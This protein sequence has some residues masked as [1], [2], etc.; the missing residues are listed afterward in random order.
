L[1]SVY[2]DRRQPT[3]NP[4]PSLLP[5]SNLDEALEQITGDD[6]VLD[7]ARQFMR[8]LASIGLRALSGR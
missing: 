6:E 3:L 1:T 5:V 7:F 2:F 4:S 8:D